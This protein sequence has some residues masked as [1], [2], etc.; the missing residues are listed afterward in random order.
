[1]A[2]SRSL[3]FKE[4]MDIFRDFESSKP[5]KNSSI[6]VSKIASSNMN[7]VLKIRL[8]HH[9]TWILKHAR[10]WVERFPEIPAPAGRTK[11]EANF[12]QWARNSPFLAASMPLYLGFDE[13]LNILVIKY[14]DN[15]LSGDSLYT[16]SPGRGIPQST[17]KNV[18]KYCAALHTAPI[19][20]PLDWKNQLLRKLNHEH[21]FLVTQREKNHLNLDNVCPGLEKLSENFKRD[22]NLSQ[23][24]QELGN[25][26]LNNDKSTMIH[27]DL[28][29][30]SWVT[31]NEQTLVL[32]PEFSFCGPPEFD[33]GVL[34]GHHL[35][36]GG[37]LSDIEQYLDLYQRC[38]GSSQEINV[39]LCKGFCGSEIIRRLLGAARLPVNFSLNQYQSLLEQGRNLCM[40]I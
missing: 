26:Y 20:Y 11:H 10:A 29:P 14:I 24:L 5:I 37:K 23:R 21:I 33:L 2:D 40:R 28:H 31:T 30:G 19:D 7:L 36:L 6:L 39:D 3:I 25:V 34:L 13:V 32:D 16:N 9:S 15:G 12:Y 22:H 4:I 17:V 8:K 18:L 1:M 27:G 38:T 35:I